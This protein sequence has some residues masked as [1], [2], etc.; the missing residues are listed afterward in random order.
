MS[1]F[2][3]QKHQSLTPYTPG[4]QPRDMQYV[5]LNTN[6]SPFPP[7]PRAMA[8]LCQDELEAL[9]LYPDPS[10][11]ELVTALA[12]IQSL[13]P[14]QVFV[15]GGSDE[16]LAYAFMAFCDSNTGLACPDVTYGFYAATADLLNLD[17]L[18]LPLKEDYTV[19]TSDYAGLNRTIVLPNPNAPTG[20]FLPLKEI[21]RLCHANPNNVVIIDEAYIDF[22]G[23]SAISLLPECENLLVIQTFSKSRSLAGGRIGMAFGSPNLIADLNRIKF[24]INPYDISRLSLRFGVAAVTDK[25]YFDACRQ[26]IMAT[27]AYTTDQLT[28]LGFRVLPSLANFVFAAPNRISGSKYYQALK[29]RGILVRHFPE[30]RIR[31]FVRITI[32]TRDQ[33]KTLLMATEEIFAEVSTL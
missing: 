21:R 16:A 23:E 9:R 5:K 28:H 22:G 14:S 10:A 4:E 29:T 24:S 25:T 12:E 2:L 31:D 13:T 32:G 33:M 20:I 30:P 15:S 11:N 17:L 3:V 18:R 8:T 7:S 6:E 26:E 19:N 27:R 1:R